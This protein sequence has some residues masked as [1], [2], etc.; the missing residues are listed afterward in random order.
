MKVRYMDEEHEIPIEN[1]FFLFVAIHAPPDTGPDW[2]AARVDGRWVPF[3]HRS[4]WGSRILGKRGPAL[5]TLP[6][7]RESTG[8]ESRFWRGVCSLFAIGDGKAGAAQVSASDLH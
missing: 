2:V 1:G 3:P 7:G 6:K 8:R 5:S 4:P